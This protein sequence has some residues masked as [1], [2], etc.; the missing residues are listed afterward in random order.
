ELKIDKDVYLIGSF[1]RDT[2]GKDL[3]SPKLIKGPDILLAIL[4]QVY[5]AH[6]NIM[7]ILAGPRR[8]WLIKQLKKFNIPYMYLGET[9]DEAIDDLQ[10]NTKSLE[11][12]SKLYNLI[13][14]YIISSRMEGGP[15]AE[16][17][18]ASTK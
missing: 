10:T 3:K 15:K 7:V 12:I 5:Q 9:Q 17:E 11:T 6:P 8:F 2:E 4:Q 18:A 1:Q 13:D 14:L 16:T